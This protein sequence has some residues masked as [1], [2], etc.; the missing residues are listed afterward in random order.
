MVAAGSGHQLLVAVPSI[1]LTVVRLGGKLG[2]DTFGG[3]F[4]QAFEQALLNPLLDVLRTEHL[5]TGLGETS[6]KG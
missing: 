2:Q 4:W 3:D 5:F 6:K 1:G